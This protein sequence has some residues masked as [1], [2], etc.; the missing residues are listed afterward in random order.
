[1]IVGV[2]DENGCKTGE[3]A[4]RSLE[5]IHVWLVDHPGGRFSAEMQVKRSLM[6]R[7]LEERAAANAVEANL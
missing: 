7:L 6:T 1:M 4:K 3:P 5:M 2:A